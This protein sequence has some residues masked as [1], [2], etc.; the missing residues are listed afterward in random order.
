MFFDRLRERD[1]DLA[2]RGDCEV[3]MSSLTSDEREWYLLLVSIFLNYSLR[4]C[5][6]DFCFERTEKAVSVVSLG[7]VY[8]RIFHFE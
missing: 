7:M 3:S 5:Y 1:F 2:G 8:G 4:L 6:F